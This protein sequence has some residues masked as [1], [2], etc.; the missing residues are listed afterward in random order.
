MKLFPNKMSTSMNFS[1]QK[2]S[3]CQ[4]ESPFKCHYKYISKRYPSISIYMQKIYFS[5]SNPFQSNEVLSCHTIITERNIQSCC[6][7]LIQVFHM[8]FSYVIYLQQ[9]LLLHLPQLDITDI[10]G[11]N[12]HRKSSLLKNK[13]LLRVDYFSHKSMH[14]N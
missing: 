5:F 6:K 9:T 13:L 7:N 11:K 12:Q 1:N 10:L 2:V 4:Q 3:K 14:S 8:S